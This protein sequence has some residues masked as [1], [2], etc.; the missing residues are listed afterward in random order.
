M[1]WDKMNASAGDGSN[2]EEY[3]TLTVDAKRDALLLVNDFVDSFLEAHDCPMK[4]QMQ[5]DLCVEEVFVNIASYAYGDKTGTAQI[6]LSGKNG[7]VTL[8]FSDEGQAYDPLAK[9]DPD[10][11]LDAESR[12][13]GGLGVFLVK[14]TMDAVSYRRENGKNILSMRKTWNV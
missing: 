12:Q 1:L 2:A 11:T 4:T 3:K 13:I 6:E 7:E 8:V 5:I 10:T 9:A 14:K